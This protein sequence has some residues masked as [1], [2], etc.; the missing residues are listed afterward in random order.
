M[1]RLS[2]R[3]EHMAPQEEFSS[4]EGEAG[5]GPG[6]LL[7]EYF[8]RSPPYSREPLADKVKLLLQL[9]IQLKIVNQSDCH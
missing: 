5:N 8:E 9:K 4:D 3:D 1:E 2:L 6:H 7:F